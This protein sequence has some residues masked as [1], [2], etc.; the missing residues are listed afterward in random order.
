MSLNTFSNTYY[1][2]KLSFFDKSNN[3][4]PLGI[5]NL[6]VIISNVDFFPVNI[7]FLVFNILSKKSTN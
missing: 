7:F 5:D 6:H 2:A 4:P 3:D 1:E